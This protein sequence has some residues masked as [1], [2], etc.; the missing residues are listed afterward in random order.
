AHDVSYF[1]K[2]NPDFL[3]ELAREYVGHVGTEPEASSDEAVALGKALKLLE[4]VRKQGQM[5]LARAKYLN[6]DYDG[7][8]RY[9]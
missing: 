6:H 1:V 7:A 4:I 2:L 8:L 3:L 5:L 9:N